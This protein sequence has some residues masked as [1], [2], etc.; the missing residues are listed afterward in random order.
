MTHVPLRMEL[1]P[2]GVSR[3]GHGFFWVGLCFVVGVAVI[4]AAMLIFPHV[5]ST[6]DGAYHPPSGKP[7]PWPAWVAMGAFAAVG[8]GVTV[9][10]LKMG[11]RRAVVEVRDGTLSIEQTD[12]FGTRRLRWRAGEVSAID[13]RATGLSVGGTKQRGG[14]SRS[15]V[16]GRTIDAL[17][18]D[19]V[20]GRSVRL[21]MG[22]DG[23]ELDVIAAQLRD[24]LGCAADAG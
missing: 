7:L 19:L 18:V 8:V 1:A 24:A 5:G 22:R 2:V 4:G 13:A 11:V 20:D 21:L 23:G 17:Y 15:G 3:A 9:A 6:I 12:L 16:H 14:V 10:G